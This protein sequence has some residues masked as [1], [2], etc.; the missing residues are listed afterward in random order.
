[1]QELRKTGRERGCLGQGGAQQA[2][3][4]TVKCQIASPKT[5]RKVKS[6]IIFGNIHEYMHISIYTY[7]NAY[8]VK[9]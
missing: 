5:Y 2:Y 7:M 1:M 8:S 9:G 4:Q 3:L 6:N